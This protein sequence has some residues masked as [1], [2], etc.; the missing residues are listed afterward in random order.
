MPSAFDELERVKSYL[1]MINFEDEDIVSLKDP[2]CNTVKD[3]FDNILEK[4]YLN[5]MN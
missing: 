2:D 3:E 5:Y 1:K 4:V